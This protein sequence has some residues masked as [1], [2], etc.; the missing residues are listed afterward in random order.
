MNKKYDTIIIDVN[1]LFMRNY[2][3]YKDDEKFKIKSGKFDFHSGGI[4]GSL[5][6]LKKLKR[7]K[8]KPEGKFIFLADNATSKVRHR[9]DIDPEYKANRVKQ[10]KAFY[11]NIDF[12]IRILS[13]YDNVSKVVQINDYEADDLVPVAIQQEKFEDSVL[14]VSSDMDWS[15]CI[16]YEGRDVEWFDGK[17]LI[18]KG[19]FL[20]KYGFDF[21]E[22]AIIIYKSFHG[23]DSDF[24]PNPVKGL[25]K[26][27]LI[28]FTQEDSVE[29][30]LLNI[31]LYGLEDKWVKKIMD[32]YGRILINKEL[33]S[34]VPVELA[35]FVFNTTFCKFN[36]KVM[37]TMFDSLQLP[38]HLN[39]LFDK[40]LKNKMKD[41]DWFTPMKRKRV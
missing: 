33:V 25:P 40:E 39:E 21:S 22:K 3:V 34:F 4:Y 17:E 2:F 13:H 5:V 18:T 7:E 28:K 23:D 30:I 31:N 12:L 16:G 10:K 15:R 11:R 6:S 14:L 37:K 41:K 29:Q 1:N 26:K 24:I 8:L 35:D 19:K 27:Y 36:Y 32:S 20:D 9:K 38:S